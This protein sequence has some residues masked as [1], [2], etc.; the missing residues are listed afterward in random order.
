MGKQPNIVWLLTDHHVFAH[1]WKEDG[2]RPSLPTYERLMREGI[3]FDN[4]HAVCPL[5]TPA[6]A[7]MLTGVYLHRHGMVMNNGDCDSR[8]KYVAYLDDRD[9][10]YDLERDPYELTN[11]VD[12]PAVLRSE[13]YAG[14]VVSAD[15]GPRRLCPRRRAAPTPDGLRSEMP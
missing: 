13:G 10:L 12:E 14:T 11:L 15:G 6:R 9:E 1:H 3:H 2:S 7:S 4:A 8:Y 5:C